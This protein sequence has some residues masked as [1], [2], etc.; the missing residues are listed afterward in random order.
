[1]CRLPLNAILMKYA[2]ILITL[3]RTDNEKIQDLA[4]AANASVMEQTPKD[5][6]GDKL[7]CAG[8]AT[9]AVRKYVAIMENLE[10]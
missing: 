3:G 4:I 6:K 2:S 8:Q 5:E 1:M 9:L 10:R 7:A